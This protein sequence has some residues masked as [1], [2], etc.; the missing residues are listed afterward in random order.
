MFA[1]FLTFDTDMMSKVWT[2]SMKL[3]SPPSWHC[4]SVILQIKKKVRKLYLKYI[5]IYIYIYIILKVWTVQLNHAFIRSSTPMLMLMPLRSIT[6]SVLWLH[7]SQHLECF[8]CD[9]ALQ[10]G[11]EFV[12]A[13]WL[14][15][16]LDS[17]PACACA[18]CASSWAIRCFSTAEINRDFWNKKKLEEIRAWKFSS[19][20]EV[21]EK[22]LQKR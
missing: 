8:S 10:F 22:S 4:S 19:K 9:S 21:R 3:R 18:A 2:H 5:Y 12:V 20:K 7:R 15:W 6:F 11:V 17:C 1:I 14:F 13:A 16:C